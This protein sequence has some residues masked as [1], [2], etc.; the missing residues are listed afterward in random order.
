MKAGSCGNRASR[1]E[2]T[3]EQEGAAVWQRRGREQEQGREKDGGRSTVGN[4][5]AKAAKAARAG[6][7]AR[8]RAV[9]L[10]DSVGV[11]TEFETNESR[12]LCERVAAKAGGT[13]LL[14]FSRGK[15]SV[16]AWLYLRRFFERVIPFHCASVPHLGYADEYIGY[17]EKF[18]GAKVE[19]YMDPGALQAFAMLVYQEPGSEAGIDAMEIKPFTRHDVAEDVRTKYG[20]HDAYCAFGISMYDSIHRKAIIADEGAVDD[21]KRMF[22]PC[23]D[24]LPSQ[25]VG[26]LRAHGVK[27]SR[28]YL[29]ARRTMAAVPG[30]RNLRRLQEIAPDDWLTVL[31]MWPMIEAE[32]ARQEFRRRAFAGR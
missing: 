9:P 32:L 6:R 23:F 30:Y 22:Y 10:A 1:N 5:P 21:D 4:R 2:A 31:D 18:F 8:V 7:A 11:T 24:W 25:V 19:R 12:R 15:D 17:C 28:D 27:L 3:M 13:C 29:M 20:L 26:Y 14:A 16:C